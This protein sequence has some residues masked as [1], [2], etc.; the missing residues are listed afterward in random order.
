[1]RLDNLPRSKN[2]RDSRGQRSGRPVML[3]GGCGMLVLLLILLLLGVNPM[4]LLDP[5]QTG[6]RQQQRSP[7]VTQPQGPQAQQQQDFIAAVLG[8]TEDIWTTQ[9]ARSGKQYRPPSLE[10]FTGYVNTACG[11]ASSAV[12]PFY[13]PGDEKIYIDPSFFDQLRVEFGASGDFAH[14]YVIAHEVGHHIQNLLGISDQ[15]HAMRNRVH[16]EEYNKQSVRLELQADFIAGV[17]ANHAQRK[18]KFLEQ[19][20][21]EEAVR[22]ANAI[23]DDMIQ[24]RTQGY[25]V[26]HAFTHGTSEQRVRWFIRGFRSGD[27]TKGNTFEIHESQL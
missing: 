6:S 15:V 2:V 21:I 26:P 19:G 5:G 27:I 3:G 10:I 13:C 7:Q 12:G 4:Q 18:F 25:V 11:R 22:A 16:K 9:F 17:W 23:G 20:D 14:A 1:M 8:T 24:K